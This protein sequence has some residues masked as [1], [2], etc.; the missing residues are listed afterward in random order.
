M[1]EN[2]PILFLPSV[3]VPTEYKIKGYGSKLNLPERDRQSH[4]DRLINSFDRILATADRIR[5]ERTA[6]SLPVKTGSYI[7]FRSSTGCDLATKS[8][9]DIRVGVK[10]LNVRE[11][12]QDGVK[13]TFA[14]V[15]IPQGQENFFIR[16]IRK[17]KNEVDKRSKLPKNFPLVTSID[18]V[19]LA[20]LESFW[21]DPPALI[22][23]DDDVYVE[24]W[25]KAIVGEERGVITETAEICQTLSIEFFENKIIYFPERIVSLIRADRS[26]LLNLIE[27]CRHV[28][29]IR[30]AKEAA[31]FWI[32]EP[33][34]SQAEWVEELIQRIEVK[35]S[36]TKVCILD[37]G[38]NNG[39]PLLAPIL[40]DNDC[41]AYNR[42]WGVA[43]DSGHGTL[44]GGVSGYG[45]LEQALQTDQPILLTHKL[46]SVKILPPVGNNDPDLYGAI[47]QQA[48]SRSEISSPNDKQIYCC[49]ITSDEIDHKGRP[50]SWSAAIDSITSGQVDDERR[51]FIVSAG[52]VKSLGEW[53][54][55]PA[56][57]LLC[58]IQDPAQSWNSL[59]V[60][61]YTE[62]TA[63]L[64]TSFNGHSALAPLR[65]LSPFSTCS[66]LW[67]SRWPIKPEI[68]LEGGNIRK[69]PDGGLYENFP[70]FSVLSTS[71]DI[72]NNQFDTIFATSA[73]S[74]KAA[75]MAAKIQTEYPN[76]WPETV[77]A[78]MVHS[79]EW[80][81]TII[82]QFGFDVQQ[83]KGVHD[84]MRVCGFGVP[85][86]NKALY[87]G[88]STLTLVAQE[89]IQPFKFND[90]NRPVSNDMHLYDLPWPKDELLG[91]GATQVKMKITLCYFVEPGP[92]EV[93]WKDRY[94]YASH[95]L[96][97]DVSN[98]NDTTEQF[99]KRISV[100]SERDEFEFI[101]DAGSE[102]WLI[103]ANNRVLG[104][105][106]SDVW[107]GNAADIATCNK[108]A[109]YPV[110]GWWRERKHLGNV[111]KNARYSLIVSLITP[112][113]E[114]DIYTPV[115]AKINVPV[116]ITM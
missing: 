86:L 9:E 99:V 112:A 71:F 92:G 73:A 89:Y 78:L 26:K 30:K 24:L 68:V 115:E 95:G 102:R 16:K 31:S 66:S 111:E 83:K 51:L 72:Q 104:A 3:A 34:V 22:P 93:G 32:N 40:N 14:T 64:D 57:N 56:S 5:S 52:N 33:N 50:T 49:A 23:G 41:N 10:L 25:L 6:V 18:D 8:L 108:I 77:K 79:A 17:F 94:R 28:A 12:V 19:R 43:D 107:E 21:T 106:H 91:L 74:A 60:G 97:F 109:V 100:A 67:E 80:P 103:G 116:S 39:H 1:S 62:K 101:G 55:Y 82:S 47:T 15:Y 54:A 37:T 61:A 81:D 7:E 84:L 53:N 85:D 65:G 48:I 42:D 76:C 114:V 70:D 105:V 113:Q 88:R 59:T 69:A 58:S 29:E 96:R 36:N 35:A 87:C 38:V 110:L 4:S 2:Y 20:I 90:D 98:I 11:K 13:Q 27:S 45:D 44:M 46:S 63:I 75:W